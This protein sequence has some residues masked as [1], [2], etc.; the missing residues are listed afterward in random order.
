[1]TFKNEIMEIQEIS[2]ELSEMNVPRSYDSKEDDGLKVYAIE[3]IASL[4]DQELS[5]SRLLRCMI[6]EITEFV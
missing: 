4:D 2:Q 6:I 5:K 1:M 3:L